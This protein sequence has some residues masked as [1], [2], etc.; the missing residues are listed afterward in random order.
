MKTLAQS[1]KEHKAEF[2]AKLCEACNGRGSVGGAMEVRCI[3]CNGKGYIKVVK[4]ND[5]PDKDCENSD[6]CG[7]CTQ[8]RAGSDANTE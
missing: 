3:E 6:I 8:Q 4:R 2:V 5:N 1:M 7:G